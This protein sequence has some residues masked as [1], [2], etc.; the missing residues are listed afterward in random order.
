MIRFKNLNN[1]LGKIDFQ[2]LDGAWGKPRLIGEEALDQGCV[3][4][5][6]SQVVRVVTLEI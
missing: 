3:W 1:T 5:D 6:S 4:A 2:G